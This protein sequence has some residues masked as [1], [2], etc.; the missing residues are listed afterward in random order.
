MNLIDRIESKLNEKKETGWLPVARKV[1]KEKSY[2]IINPKTNDISYDKE[3]LP[4][5]KTG[6]VLLDLTTANMLV[7]IADALS[8]ESNEKFSSTPLLNAVKIGWQLVKK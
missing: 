5:K 4:K 6:Y 8:K 2:V 1:V 3:G 7:T